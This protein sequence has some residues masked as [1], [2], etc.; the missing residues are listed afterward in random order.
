MTVP[1]TNLKGQKSSFMEILRNALNEKAKGNASKK[2]RPVLKFSES[3]WA[4][5]MEDSLKRSSNPTQPVEN[6]LQDEVRTNDTVVKRELEDHLRIMAW[7]RPGPYYEITFHKNRSLGLIR[8]RTYQK[9]LRMKSN[10]DLP[11]RS[12]VI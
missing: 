7:E 3:T 1:L 10:E 8:T 12:N 5:T 11:Y 6:A 4:E 2:N 9:Q